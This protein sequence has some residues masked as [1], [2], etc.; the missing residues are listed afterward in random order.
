MKQTIIFQRYLPPEVIEK[1]AKEFKTFYA[2]YHPLLKLKDSERACLFTIYTKAYTGKF[3]DDNEFAFLENLK[4]TIQQRNRNSSKRSFNEKP[5]LDE[6]KNQDEQHS[7]DDAFDLS[8]SEQEFDKVIDQQ[9]EDSTHFINKIV[10]DDSDLYEVQFIEKKNDPK[11]LW[12]EF[13]EFLELISKQVFLPPSK[14]NFEENKEIKVLKSEEKVIEQLSNKELSDQKK[15]KKKFRKFY[16]KDVIILAI[17]GPLLVFL[18][19][20]L[21]QSHFF[22]LSFILL[23]LFVYVLK[24]SGSII[25]KLFRA[26]KG[27]VIKHNSS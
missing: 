16:L 7:W 4:K 12:E 14:E 22:Q 21:T 25:K 3:L 2:Q 27:I 11:Q 5:P 24:S 20:L 6:I 13:H 26:F 15:G 10:N 19:F 8:S 17:T 1:L 18:T 23:V 9:L